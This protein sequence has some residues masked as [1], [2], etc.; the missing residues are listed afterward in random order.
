M[1][2]LL[3]T[4]YAISFSNS[5]I[6]SGRSNQTRLQ[7]HQPLILN[8]IGLIDHNLRSQ[9]HLWEQLFLTLPDWLTQP[10]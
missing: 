1:S 9:V 6:K 3:A 10:R 5:A 2:L 7:R 4:N 8:S